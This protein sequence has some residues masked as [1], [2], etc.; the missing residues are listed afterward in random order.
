MITDIIT[1]SLIVGFFNGLSNFVVFIGGGEEA[2]TGKSK[3]RAAILSARGLAVGSEEGAGVGLGV[4]A[5]T[6]AAVGCP[7][8]GV[9]SGVGRGVGR[10]LGAADGFGV[11]DVDGAGVGPDV[12]GRADG[13]KLTVGA[14]VGRSA[15][16]VQR[17]A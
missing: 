5:K 6:G 14:A 17:V 4:G 2:L 9:G 1:I 15:R 13:L 7:G 3:L 11:G 8:T 16:C 12:V 10:G